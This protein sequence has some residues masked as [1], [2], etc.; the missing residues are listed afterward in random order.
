MKT[1]RPSSLFLTIALAALSCG[2]Q[3]EVDKV[4]D[5]EAPYTEELS[6]SFEDIVDTKML[7]DPATGLCTWQED[8]PI[9]VHT[10]SGWYYAPV[11][12]S[13]VRLNLSSTQTRQNYAIYPSTAPG[14]SP[15]TPNVAYPSSYD[16]VGGKNLTN[17]TPAPMVAI[18]SATTSSLKFFH[19][20]GVVNLYLTNIPSGTNS[21]TVTFYGKTVIGTF[22][23]TDAG[24]ADALATSTG[25]SNSTITYSNC[26][27]ASSMYLNIPIPAGDYSTLTKIT[28]SAS[29][30]SVS[31]TVTREIPGGWGTIGHAQGKKIHLDFV[32]I[33]GG[34]GTFGANNLKIG[35]FLKWDTATNKYTLIK[36]PLEFCLNKT[37]AAKDIY[38]HIYS[39]TTNSLRYRTTNYTTCGLVGDIPIDGLYYKMVGDV[40]VDY[41]NDLS[42][43]CDWYK[44]IESAG[45]CTINGNTKRNG[46]KILLDLNLATPANGASADYRNKGFVS[47]T[48]G[49]SHSTN[50]RYIP[51]FLL[52]PN[53]SNITCPEIKQDYQSYYQYSISDNVIT[54]PTYKKLID[55]GCFFIPVG[56]YISGSTFTYSDGYFYF[57]CNVNTSSY[58][59]YAYIRIYSSSFYVSRSS[60]NSPSGTNQYWLPVLVI[61]KQ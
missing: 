50:N 4:S 17:H 49:S 23:V 10:T 27:Y 42:T 6:V 15:A 51:G 39:G 61:Q 47:N 12:G 8:D 3:K 55:G 1:T 21:F 32:S 31:P 22:N 44:L 30:G 26:T 7:L 29:G 54:Y 20:G 43:S 11:A 60:I 18:N 58:A 48:D 37:S 9:A 53:G 41:Y 35:G 28:V 14:N 2:C 36:D 24:T 33:T 40:G 13:S 25:T 46:V 52:C 45:T 38:Y 16:M 5:N 34:N 19:V 56:G 57:H 59:Y